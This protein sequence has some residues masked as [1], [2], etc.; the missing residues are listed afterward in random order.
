[1]TSRANRTKW[2]FWVYYK[3]PEHLDSQLVAKDRTNKMGCTVNSDSGLF[4]SKIQTRWDQ[5]C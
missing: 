3:D 5:T 2:L 4:K 1:M